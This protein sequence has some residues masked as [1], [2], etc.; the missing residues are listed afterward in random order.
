MPLMSGLWGCAPERSPERIVVGTRGDI[1]TIDPAQAYQTRSLQLISALGDPLYERRGDGSLVPRLAAA[2]PQVSDDGLRV[3]IP[4]RDGVL[5]HD[6]TPFDA[7]AM[8]FSLRRFR[9]AGGFLSF[10]LDNVEAVTV[11]GP[12]ELEL[13]LQAPYAPLLNLLSFAGLTPVSAAAYSEDCPNETANETAADDASLCLRPDQFVGTGPY[14]LSYRNADGTQHRLDRFPDYWGDP[15]RNEGIDIVS[16]DNSTAL[17]GALKNGEV[18]VLSSSGLEVEHQLELSRGAAAGDFR[19]VVSPPL[20]IEV[21]AIA[22]DRPPLDAVAVRRALA[23]SLPRNLLSQRVSQGLNAPLR[24][25]VPDQF[26]SAT[27]S[28]PELNVAE[29]RKLLTVEDYCNGNQLQVPFTFRSNVPTDQLVALTWQEFLSQEL[30]DCLVLEPTGLESAT[31]YEQLSKGAFSMVI[32]DWSPD[33]LDPE[34]YLRPFLGCDAH[35]GNIC[36]EGPAVDSGTFWFDAQADALLALQQGQAPAARTATLVDLQAAV[37]EGV[38][39]IPLWQT[40]RRVWSQEDVG[41]LAHDGSG[42]LR[43]SALER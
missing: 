4:L 39:Y 26:P 19:E 33:F 40:S 43:F 15:A 23:L 35:T 2:L 20:G 41:G 22:T 38:P 34:N 14:R 6:G 36:E 25:L 28:W 8:A 17:F 24:S 11:T 13:Q 21:L 42:W 5:F 9:D 7:E 27:S 31:L 37:A 3:R 29:A 10:L 30:G 1:A 32:Y 18:D 16:L 12:L